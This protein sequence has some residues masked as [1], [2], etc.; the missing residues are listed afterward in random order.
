MYQYQ[1]TS[2]T[3]ADSSDS[4]HNFTV[5]LS[6]IWKIN[7]QVRNQ[8]IFWFWLI[9]FLKRH[10]AFLALKRFSLSTWDMSYYS[11]Q[12]L[13]KKVKITFL[14]Q[15][16]TSSFIYMNSCNSK[17]SKF[18]IVQFF[19]FW[20][21]LIVK[22]PYIEHISS[23]QTRLFGS[24]NQTVAALT[25]KKDPQVESQDPLPGGLVRLFWF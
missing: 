23:L 10:W 14:S 19:S 2:A 15:C 7:Q 18:V 20:M 25:A 5:H 6:R 3:E 16:L 9:C 21:F 22:S 8:Q 24:L 1:C 4:I 12:D 11:E 17:S 13:W